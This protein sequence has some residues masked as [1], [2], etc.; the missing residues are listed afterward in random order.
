MYDRSFRTTVFGRELRKFRI[1][2]NMTQK[3]IGECIGASAN[4]IH[5]WE[6]RVT[7]PNMA[8]LTK[9]AEI[10]GKPLNKLIEETLLVWDEDAFTAA[11]YCGSAEGQQVLE[12]TGDE[13]TGTGYYG[14]RDGEP[15]WR[16][17]A[18][19]PD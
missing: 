13:G 11:A 9:L 2:K 1:R 14:S 10:M 12:G 18:D 3:Q 5:L 4:T 15:L 16:T 19:R 6:T 7:K 17:E 8:Y